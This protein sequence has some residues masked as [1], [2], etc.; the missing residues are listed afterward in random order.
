MP[1][2]TG[3]PGDDFIV[4]TSESESIAGG[5]GNDRIEGGLGVDTLDGGEGD[6][7]LTDTDS[8]GRYLG[9]AGAGDD[10]I[11]ISPGF[12]SAKPVSLYLDGGD[13]PDYL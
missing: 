4:G 12:Q 7:Y 5:A 6:D 9:G 1:T 2:I 3:T 13:G 11:I 8:S 10:I